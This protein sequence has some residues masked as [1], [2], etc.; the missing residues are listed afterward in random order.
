MSNNEISKKL[1]CFWWGSFGA[2]IVVS[3]ALVFFINK[4]N[5]KDVNKEFIFSLLGIIFLL[6]LSIISVTCLNFIK[7]IYKYERIKLKLNQLDQTSQQ[8][9]QVQQ[10]DRSENP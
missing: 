4:M 6:S 8:V 10:N 9:S 7:E 5:P 1:N 2:I 3:L